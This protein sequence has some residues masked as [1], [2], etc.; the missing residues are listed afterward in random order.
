M[1][2]IIYMDNAATTRVYPEV[3]EAMEPY[4]REY[5]GNPASI[6]QFSQKNQIALSKSRELI[7]NS[8]HAAN[9]NEI[10]FTGGGSEGN[11][12]I[13]KGIAFAL[14]EK[15]NHI[16]TSKIEH[17]S[18]LYVCHFLEKIGYEVTYL[19]VDENGL[20]SLDQLVEAIRPTTILISIM[21]ANNE[22]GT[23][24]PI[25]RI[26]AIAKAHGVL[27]HTDAVQAYMHIPID[28]QEMGIDLLSAS[29]HKFHGPKG[30]GFVYIRNGISIESLVHGGGQERSKRAGTHNVPAIVGMAK[31]AELVYANMEENCQKEQELRDYL[32][33]RITSEISGVKVYGDR[34]NRLS[35]NVNV[36]FQGI[37][38]EMLLI[39]LDQKHIAASGGSACTADS[40]KPSHVLQAM[41]VPENSIN[42]T[43][44]LTVS[45]D[46]TKKEMDYVVDNLVTI[47]DN[48]RKHCL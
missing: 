26:G 10:Y 30:A 33:E 22:V 2:D 37:D 7:G 4:W 24:E 8:I 20:V 29:A 39:L 32:L 14:K 18:V 45:I 43:L 25:A 13:L 46:N 44:R 3:V 28:V 40:L 36:S 12:W 16:I 5:Y 11:N 48:L 6:Y 9:A 15:G 34:I 21:A 42:G 31:A 23:L 47:V 38:R 35:N 1:N 17:H 19:D 41:G 27:F